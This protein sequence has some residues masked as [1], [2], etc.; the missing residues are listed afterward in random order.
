M[1]RLIAIAVLAAIPLL[2]HGY[3]PVPHAPSPEGGIDRAER[4]VDIATIGEAG[5]ITAALD[6]NGEGLALM[7]SATLPYGAH[8][9]ARLGLAAGQQH[10]AE[11]A[12]AQP[13]G[14]EGAAAPFYGIGATYRVQRLMMHAEYERYDIG[15]SGEMIE[16]DRLS[17]RMSYHF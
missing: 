1:H 14:R 2:A 17:A 4:A 7:G 12:L 13:D 16:T 9:Y 3:E 15:E 5:P 10:H 6:L 11:K 8:L